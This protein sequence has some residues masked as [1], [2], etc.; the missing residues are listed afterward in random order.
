MK[1]LNNS[2]LASHYSRFTTLKNLNK[3]LTSCS[4]NLTDSEISELCNPKYN[5]TEFDIYKYITAY[6]Y[7]SDS[8]NCNKYTLTEGI[9][10]NKNK[11]NNILID[12]F[13]INVLNQLLTQY[14][15]SI[16]FGIKKEGCGITD[17]TKLGDIKIIKG[18]YPYKFS[19]KETRFIISNEGD[20]SSGLYNYIVSI[21][22]IENNGKI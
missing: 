4:T 14:P 3:Q 19:L 7:I 1:F 9:T 18:Q 12:L 11:Y 10:L 13:Y 6:D 22:G 2:L 20:I 16:T 5:L 21:R 8:L 15:I 17:L